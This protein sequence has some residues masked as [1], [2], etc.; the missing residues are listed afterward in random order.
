[1]NKGLKFITPALIIITLLCISAINKNASTKYVQKKGV[2][3]IVID[4]G[5][6]GSDYGASGAY[7]YEKN[8]SLAV[9]LKLEQMIKK[10]IGDVEVYMTRTED[11]YD[12]VKVKANKANAAGGDLFI[13]IHCN[14]A[15]AKKG[16]ELIGYETKRVKK[17]GKWR[18]VQVPQYRYYTIPT[19]AKGTETYIWGVNKNDDKEK[20]LRENADLFKD[21]SMDAELKNFDPYSPEQAIA[22]SLRTQQYAERS[23]N[24]AFNV[25][26]EFI[27]IGR[28]NRDVRQRGVGIWVLQAVAMPAILVELG[29]IS[30]PEEEAYL[31]SEEGQNALAGA[32]ATAVKK[33]KEGI[34][35]KIKSTSQPTR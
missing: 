15:P 33:Y 32:I 2:R 28:S 8:V 20:A 17:K 21:S 22:I 23:I 7:S 14:D 4:A 9:A 27:N 19:T 16:R 10:E 30:N 29:F 3:K 6:G 13:S 11:F 25:Q 5:H 35:A 26:Q 31:N 24:L 12:N 34:E 1:M 18:S